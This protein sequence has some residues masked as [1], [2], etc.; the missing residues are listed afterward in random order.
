MICPI[1]LKNASQ[2]G[3]SAE[4]FEENIIKCL[5]LKKPPT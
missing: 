4:T 2:C 5:F 1:K 3:V